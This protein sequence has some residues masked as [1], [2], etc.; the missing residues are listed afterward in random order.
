MFKE[1]KSNMKSMLCGFPQGSILGPILFRVYIND[2]ANMS[3]KDLYCSQMT[4]MYFTMDNHLKMY[5]IN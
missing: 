4:L 3:N 1:T 2:I 5:S